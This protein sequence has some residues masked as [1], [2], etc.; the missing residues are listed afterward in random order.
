MESSFA[1]IYLALID[2]INTL[3]IGD[4]PV[5]EITHIDMDY[6]QLE[7]ERPPVSYPCVLIDFQDWRYTNNGNLIQIAEGNIIVKIATDPHSATSG[8]TPDTYREAALYILDLENLIYTLL[9][10]YRVPHQYDPN[11]PL[12]VTKQTTALIRTNS[13]TDNRRVGMKIK[14]LTFRTSFT[15]LAAS[16]LPRSIPR[17]PL[18][19]TEQIIIPT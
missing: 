16:T 10:G 17:P 5:P 11:D 19:I 8:N 15:D 3:L 4:P 13:I 9:Q 2:K 12:I 1:N 18:D 6:G 14:E 7:Q